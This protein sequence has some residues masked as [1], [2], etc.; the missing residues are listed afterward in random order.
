MA[1][2]HA[3]TGSGASATASGV[4]AADGAAVQAWLGSQMRGLRCSVCGA[5]KSRVGLM[6]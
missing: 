2:A 1:M 6:P 5:T 4:S 3:L